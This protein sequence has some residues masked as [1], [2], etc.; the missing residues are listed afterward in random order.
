LGCEERRQ[1]TIYWKKSI[2]WCRVVRYLSEFYEF[3]VVFIDVFL[4]SKLKGRG[5]VC[6]LPY[7]PDAL[8]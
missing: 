5:A 4:D 7:I 6:L 8:E 3:A 2:V 1:K